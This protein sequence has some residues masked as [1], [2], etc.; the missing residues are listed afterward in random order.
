MCRG[1]VRGAVAKGQRAQTIVYR[2]ASLPCASGFGSRA[3]TEAVIPVH[4]WMGGAKPVPAQM[5][6]GE[7]G[8]GNAEGVSPVP[9]MR[10][11]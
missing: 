9:V 4:T 11:G 7:P 2:A 3:N 6:E 1:G 5:W 10:E 8:P